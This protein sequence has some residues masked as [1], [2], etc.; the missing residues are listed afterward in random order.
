ME[1]F[2]AFVLRHRLWVA[3][4]WVAVTVVGVHDR[5]GADGA[6]NPPAPHPSVHA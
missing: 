4:A 1:R 2:A 3:L 5:D 6:L